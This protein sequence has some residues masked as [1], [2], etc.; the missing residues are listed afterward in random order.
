[1]GAART[2]RLDL[3]AEREKSGGVDSSHGEDG[4][5][6]TTVVGKGRVAQKAIEKVGDGH[7][8]RKNVGPDKPG[9]DV[10]GKGAAFRGAGAIEVD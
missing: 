2:G 10:E 1:M 9:Q 6:K 4:I 7:L 5:R 3:E 8:P